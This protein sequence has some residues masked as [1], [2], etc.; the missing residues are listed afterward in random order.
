MGVPGAGIVVPL[1]RKL[2]ATQRRPDDG[3]DDMFAGTG[4]PL[5]RASHHA[6][7]ILPNDVFMRR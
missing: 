4:Q 1:H 3:T 5:F 2:L 7:W 6:G